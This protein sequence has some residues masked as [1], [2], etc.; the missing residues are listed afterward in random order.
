MEFSFC[1]LGHALGVGVLGGGGVK[2]FSVGIC[3]GAPLTGRSS[4][5][6]ELSALLVILTLKAP[7]KNASGRREKQTTFV[8]IGALR[9]KVGFI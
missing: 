9:V 8:A 7:R 5:Y 6:S 4:F 2:N 3:D 1:G